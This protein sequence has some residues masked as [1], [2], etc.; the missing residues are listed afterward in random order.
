VLEEVQAKLKQQEEEVSRLNGELVL[1]SISH[2]D[3]RSPSRGRRCRSKVNLLSPAFRLLIRSFGIRSQLVFLCSW[4]PG[5]RT[6]LGH[7]TT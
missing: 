2:E 1:I 7:A 6:A 4:L 3:Q 5:Q